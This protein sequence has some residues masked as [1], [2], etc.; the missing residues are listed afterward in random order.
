VGKKRHG[1]H[2]L[3]PE[4]PREVIRTLMKVCYKH[5]KM[6]GDDLALVPTCTS[7]K[8]RIRHIVTI[9]VTRRRLLVSTLSYI[10][11]NADLS[12]KEFLDLRYDC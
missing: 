3:V 6:K 11:R 7:S 5:G 8:D 10:L 12:T 4:R 2:K 1:P 9:P